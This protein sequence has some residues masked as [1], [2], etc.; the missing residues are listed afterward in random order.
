M[1]M[2]P[3]LLALLAVFCTI[4]PQA[5]GAAQGGVFSNIPPAKIELIDLKPEP[6]GESCLLDLSKNGQIFSFVARFDRR[7]KNKELLGLMEA[8]S[9]EV[10]AYYRLRFDPL[11]RRL[12]VALL[13]PKKMI[14]RYATSTIDTVL[15]YLAAREVDFRLKVFDS[16]SEDLGAL[17]AAVSEIL[18]EKFSFMVAVLSNEDS[19]KALE[20]IDIPIYIPTMSAKNLTRL[21]NDANDAPKIPANIVFGGIDYEEQIRAL[22]AKVEAK[23]AIIYNDDSALGRTLGTLTRK[24]HDN[25][26]FE[27]IITNKLAANFSQNIASEERHFA[28][29]NIFLNTPVVKSGLILSQIAASKH[30]PSAILST[31]V[32]FSPA[33]LSLVRGNDTGNILIAN[34]INQSVGELVEYGLLLTSDMRYD[35]VNY[36]TALGMD[37]FLTN[38]TN[39]VERIFSEALEDN[40]VRYVVNLYRIVNGA[41]VRSE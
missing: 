7:T 36:A 6:C 32:N 22:L 17:N 8:H 13:L 30:R 23:N 11:G 27:D 29:S 18:S 4:L 38:M 14:G 24:L 37:L 35:W 39:G 33:F 2:P 41:F 5:L 40:Q 34:S 9:R 20:N 26:L 16:V 12:D 10:G 15:A 3:F 25:V 19:L 31:Q 28:S 21:A 1:K